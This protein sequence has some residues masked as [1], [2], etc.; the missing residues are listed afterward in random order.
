MPAVRLIDWDKVARDSCRE[1][2]P[3]K[4]DVP[5][6]TDGVFKVPLPIPKR[7][8]QTN[9]IVNICKRAR[10]SP[11]RFSEEHFEPTRKRFKIEADDQ[12]PRC[13]VNDI[14]FSS[15]PFETFIKN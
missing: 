2:T 6:E 11:L 7:S 8:S 4:I 3:V 14:N 9:E 10:T 1:K 15:I 13:F 5:M 12:E